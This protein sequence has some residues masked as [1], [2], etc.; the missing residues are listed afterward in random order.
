MDPCIQHPGHIGWFRSGQVTWPA[1]GRMTLS[2]LQDAELLCC[3]VYCNSVRLG[4]SCQTCPGAGPT[5]G[6]QT[7]RPEPGCILR[8]LNEAMAEAGTVYGLFS[9]CQP[10]AF[11]IVNPHRCQGSSASHIAQTTKQA[12]GELSEL[13][14]VVQPD[15]AS[16]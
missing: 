16:T 5:W 12:E 2:T 14:K 6:S 7:T 11:R 3:P 9:L 8:A 1:V 4:Q 10:H 15:K 13:A